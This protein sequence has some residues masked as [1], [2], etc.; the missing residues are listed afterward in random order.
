MRDLDAVLK[1]LFDHNITINLDKTCFCR[2]NVIYL[3]FRA[4]DKGVAQDRALVDKI[5]K[6]EVPLN[7][8]Q[9]QS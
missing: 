9:P 4:S 6:M 1:R 5:C 2:T 8:E 7:Y 3:G